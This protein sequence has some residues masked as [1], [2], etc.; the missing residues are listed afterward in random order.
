MGMTRR[1][2]SLNGLETETG[3]D[4]RTLGKMLSTV[5]PDGRLGKHPAWYLTTVLSAIDRYEN[6]VPSRGPVRPPEIPAAF[7]A[8][9]KVD[10]SVHGGMIFAALHMT[11]QV[12]AVAA[13]MAVMSGAPVRVAWMLRKSMI[14]G[15]MEK[16]LEMCREGRIEPFAHDEEALTVELKAFAEND[17]KALARM[18]GEP[19]DEPAWEAYAR[20]RSAR[21]NGGKI[22]PPAELASEPVVTGDRWP[23]TGILHMP[24]QPAT[25]R[26]R[27]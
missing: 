15:M 10:E 18:A 27:G 7:N 2:W 23:K 8:M 1:L 20:E 5:P 17:W 6:P 25:P 11:Y 24:N 14:L 4:R 12:P 19:F 9:L 21:V 13:V 3:R 22:C 26:W 16:T